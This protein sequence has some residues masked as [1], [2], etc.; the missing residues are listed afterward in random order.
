MQSL[1]RNYMNARTH[2]VSE[3]MPMRPTINIFNNK[4]KSANWT[5]TFLPIDGKPAYLFSVKPHTY[6]SPF[7]GYCTVDLA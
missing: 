1:E 5:Y 4:D 3:L 6:S 2:F 7:R